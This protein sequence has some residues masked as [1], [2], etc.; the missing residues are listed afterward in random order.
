MIGHSLAVLNYLSTNSDTKGT[1]N[2]TNRSPIPPS[3]QGVTPMH[4]NPTS[5]DRLSILKYQ[6]FFLFPQLDDKF[7][8]DLS[9]KKHFHLSYI[10]TLLLLGSPLLLSVNLDTLYACVS[11]HKSTMATLQHRIN[12]NAC[13]E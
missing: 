2:I 7:T 11:L 12:D 13:A 8:R 4:I 10:C 5:H 6:L 9:N 1:L 3:P